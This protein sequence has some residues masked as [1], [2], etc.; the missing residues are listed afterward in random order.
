MSRC[1]IEWGDG[2]A[3]ENQARYDARLDWTYGPMQL[4]DDHAAEERGFWNSVIEIR[5]IRPEVAA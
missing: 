5:S 2:T 4:C 3:C 1:Y